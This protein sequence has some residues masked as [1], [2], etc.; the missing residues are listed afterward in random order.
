[1]E[2]QA[3]LWGAVAEVEEQLQLLDA[4]S[5]TGLVSPY[6]H[7]G[8]WRFTPQKWGGELSTK[9][10]EKWVVKVFF[11]DI[12]QKIHPL[13]LILNILGLYDQTISR[14]FSKVG[15]MQNMKRQGVRN[16][17]HK[18]GEDGERVQGAETA[19]RNHW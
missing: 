13:F 12:L 8:G 5:P 14:G 11:K 10:R 18:G 1:M 16:S 4:A 15:G 2:S 7:F 6:P 19:N 9:Q 3:R 17:W